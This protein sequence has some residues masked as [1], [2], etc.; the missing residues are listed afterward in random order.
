MNRLKAAVESDPRGEGEGAPSSFSAYERHMAI[1]VL[2]SDLAHGI[3]PAMT[4]LREILR[5][6]E[7]NPTDRSIGDEEL[8][9]LKA[10]MSA[11]RRTKR[12]ERSPRSLEV[13]PAI[14]S[15][16]E[17]ARAEG[18]DTARVTVECEQV[19]IWAQE[20][21]L[22]LALICLLRNALQAAAN[23]AV[24][25]SARVHGDRLCLQVIDDGPG[26]PEAFVDWAF[27]PL[28]ALAADG[29][30]TGLAVVLGIV[31]DH[32]WDV[33]HERHDERTVF[34]LDIQLGRPQA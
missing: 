23:G 27:H 13:A 26:L 12:R 31:R 8:A 14:R 4:F 25:I 32:G 6:A 29:H 3:A 1:A 15:A 28:A 7:M 22:E 10:L 20:R 18:F 16:V 11:L 34:A 33:T 5:E 21:A 24:S 2:C 17:R 9:R 19:S 30:G